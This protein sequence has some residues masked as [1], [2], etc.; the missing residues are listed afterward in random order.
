MIFHICFF[1]LCRSWYKS[2]SII[3]INFYT[4]FIQ[5]VKKRSGIKLK[6]K[7]F[8]Q[9]GGL[10]LERQLSSNENNVQNT[11]LF[12]SKEL[13]K[14]TDNFS[15]SRILGKGGYGTVFKGMLSDGRIVAIK[16]CNTMYEGNQWGLQEF[17]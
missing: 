1:D 9:N 14:A 15:K 16:K 11:K 10:L 7:F 8:K 12:N 5:S 13:E 3:S 2:G 17:S 6:K 4:G